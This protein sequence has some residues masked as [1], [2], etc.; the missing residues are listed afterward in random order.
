M[1][2]GDDAVSDGMPVVP[3]TGQVR[4]GF[5]E[6]N[7]TRD[8]IAQRN[9]ATRPVNRGGTGSTTAAGARTNLGAM[10]SSWR[11]K[12]S[13]VTG[14]PSVFKPSAH[15]HGLGEIGGDLVNRLPNLEA[16]R[17]S[18]LPWDRP[19][20]WTR[21]AAYMGNNGQIL[22]G[23][24]ESTR[25]SKTDLANVEWTREQLQAIPVLHY[26][27]IAELQKQA[28]DPDYHVSLELG[29]IAEDLHDLGLWEFVHYE[30]HGESA[31]PSGVH[32]ELLGLAALRLAQL[33]GER[34]DALEERLNALEAM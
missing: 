34:L 30:G 33:Q 16:G 19:I 1:A 9:K 8:M 26:R 29:T 11:P 13:E 3:E 23:H 7:R 2:I 12:W 5:E 14:K 21:R 4:K 15:G 27:Y 31:I 28:E 22:L 18:P 6:I 10:A 32:Y 24:V 25:A 17:L 20:T